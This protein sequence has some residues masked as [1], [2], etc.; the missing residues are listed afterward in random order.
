MNITNCAITGYPLKPGELKPLT[1]TTIEYETQT[2]G[3][4]KITIPAYNELYSGSFERYLIAGICK[5]RTLNDL[6]P[7]L[8]DS[9]FIREGYKNEN[10]PVEFEEKCYALLKV[11]YTEGGKENKEFELNSTRDFPLAYADNEEFCRIVDQLENSHHIT[12][13]KT[14]R[15]ARGNDVKLFMGVKLTSTGKNEAQKALPKMPMVNLV[16]QTISTGDVEVDAK[17]NHARNLFFSEPTSLDKM[18]SACETLS[19]ILEPLR[20]DL[21]TYFGQKDVADFFQ[22]VNTFDIRHNKEMTK[23][24]VFPEQL[25]WVFYTLLNTINTYTKIKNR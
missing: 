19:Y 13:R 15:M 9:Q 7:L 25:E 2:V 6:E 20:E 3:K 14:H 24:I 11:L 22:I 8:I 10:P 5:H 16:N 17:I 12:V 23:N 18:R 4:V 1:S 21:K